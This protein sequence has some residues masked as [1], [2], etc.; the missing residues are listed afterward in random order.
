[1]ARELRFFWDI[2]GFAEEGA[3]TMARLLDI[4]APC[5]TS[6]T[7]VIILC[8]ASDM[9]ERL[10]DRARAER[11]VTEATER[12]TVMGDPGLQLTAA[13]S[14]A[15]LFARRGEFRQAA[16]ALDGHSLHGV[17]GSDFTRFHMVLG[18]VRI[19]LDD[20]AGSRAALQTA[21]AA[22]RNLGDDRRLAIVLSDLSVVA[23]A[24]NDLE[25][26]TRHLEEAQVLAARLGDV[27]MLGYVSLNLGLVAIS[28][29]RPG[30]ARVRYREALLLSTPSG[31]LSLVHASIL[32]LTLCCSAEGED[33][34]AAVLHGFLDAAE[35]RGTLVLDPTESTLR[36][37]DRDRLRAALS[38]AEVEQLT[39]EGRALT[40]P[41]AVALAKDAAGRQSGDEPLSSRP[42]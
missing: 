36:Q 4:A 42:G 30:P 20:P 35:D 15:Q 32:G 25:A 3:T 13:I 31:E 19:G 17:E 1:M 8:G 41:E 24:E 18:Y 12:A 23:M 33:S 10:G 5:R 21:E 7:Y 26:A 29:G 38:A 34:M 22:V 14:R 27:S 37:R 39:Q 40:V 6:Q 16:A 9:F 28:E 11:L 2:R